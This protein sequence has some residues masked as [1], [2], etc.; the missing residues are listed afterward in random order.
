MLKKQDL[1][2]E[3][4]LLESIIPFVLCTELRHI[5]EGMTNILQRNHNAVSLHISI[6]HITHSICTNLPPKNGLSFAIWKH[7]LQKFH[8]RGTHSHF[9]KPRTTLPPHSG[10]QEATRTRTRLIC[11]LSR[12]R[13]SSRAQ[14]RLDS[15][16]PR[17]AQELQCL[18]GQSMRAPQ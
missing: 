16:W 10:P 9:M 18:P 1:G 11:Y 5:L 2:F 6:S 7:N 17:P 13:A 8:H 15:W 3:V 12:K 4:A 14:R